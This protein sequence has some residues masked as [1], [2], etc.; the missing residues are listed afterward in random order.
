MSSNQIADG[1][2]Y[3]IHVNEETYLLLL[4]LRNEYARRAR[5]NVSFAWILKDMTHERYAIL[6]QSEQKG[7]LFGEYFGLKNR[8]TGIK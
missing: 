8:A 5:R 1:K 2:R 3:T 4:S 7:Y 6:V